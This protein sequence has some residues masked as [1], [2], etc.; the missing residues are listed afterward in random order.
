ML[1]GLPEAE[2]NPTNDMTIKNS[3]HCLRLL[4]T[5]HKKELLN[6]YEKKYLQFQ[7]KIRV[8]YNMPDLLPY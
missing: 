3:T 2:A 6:I 5:D 4:L 8:K 1:Y 7:S